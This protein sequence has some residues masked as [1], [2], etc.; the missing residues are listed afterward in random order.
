MKLC[1]LRRSDRFFPFLAWVLGFAAFTPWQPASAGEQATPSLTIEQRNRLE[2]SLQDSTLAPWQRQ[3]MEG[4]LGPG[5]RTSGGSVGRLP[6]IGAADAAGGWSLLTGSLGGPSE[7][8]YD[9]I[10]DRMILF[11]GRKVSGWGGDLWALDF[12]G[13]VGVAPGV[14]TPAPRLAIERARA[15]DSAILLDLALAGAAPLRVEILDVAG[16]RV[17]EMNA[18]ASAQL[19]VPVAAGSGV[20]FLRVRQGAHEARGRIALVR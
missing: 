11:G 19:R 9:P 18:E 7:A 2:K 16:R 15:Q 3:V 5:A 10:R 13:T 14:S 12:S 6:A 1:S 4:F 17:A 20:Y 8:I